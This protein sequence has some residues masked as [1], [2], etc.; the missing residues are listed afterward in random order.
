MPSALL[1]L[2]AIPNCKPITAA[3]MTKVLMMG[4]AMMTPAVAMPMKAPITVG[5]IV[6]AR[7]K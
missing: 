4:C 3:S 2:A 7:S 1:R 5:T 6:R